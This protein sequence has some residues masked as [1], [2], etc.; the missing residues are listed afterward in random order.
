MK[1]KSKEFPYIILKYTR[2]SLA[3]KSIIKTAIKITGINFYK[4]FCK[5]I[6]NGTKNLSNVISNKTAI[7]EQA[8]VVKKYIHYRWF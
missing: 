5:E 1:Q 7:G 8:S 3:I 6:I 2:I 4:K